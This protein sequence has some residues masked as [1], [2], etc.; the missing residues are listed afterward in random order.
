VKWDANISLDLLLSTTLKEPTRYRYKDR[1][2]GSIEKISNEKRQ[3]YK[4]L[5]YEYIPDWYIA[6]SDN[7]F[8]ICGFSDKQLA[9]YLL[10]DAILNMVGKALERV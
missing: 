9:D 3:K 7:R 1:P 5:E 4:Q 2:I 8:I 6:Y 10:L